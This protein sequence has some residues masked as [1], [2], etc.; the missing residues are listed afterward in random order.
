MNGE[1]GFEDEAS[2][3]PTSSRHLPV[4]ERVIVAMHRHQ[5]GALRLGAMAEMA[6]LS[7]YHFTRTFRSITGVPPG[8]GMVLPSFKVMLGTALTVV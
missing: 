5:D 4:V 6:N 7:P 3:G 8:V 1:P 2:A